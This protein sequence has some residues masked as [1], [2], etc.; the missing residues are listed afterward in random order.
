MFFILLIFQK[1]FT[2]SWKKKRAENNFCPE[3]NEVLKLFQTYP[4]IFFYSTTAYDGVCCF[5]TVFLSGKRTSTWNSSQPSKSA[6]TINR[7]QT[8][9]RMVA[10]FV[11]GIMRWDPLYNTFLFQVLSLGNVYLRATEERVSYEYQPWWPAEAMSFF[12][13][14]DVF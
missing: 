6:N 9:K 10:L 14:H 4:Q 3:S 2:F 7:Y 13:I 5:I 11:L 8:R 12:P 1:K